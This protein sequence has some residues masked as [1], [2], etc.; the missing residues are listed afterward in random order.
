MRLH[1]KL[2]ADL[3]V[4]RRYLEHFE[5]AGETPAS[6]DTS[7]RQESNEDQILREF[8]SSHEIGRVNFKRL[9]KCS[10]ATPLTC[11]INGK[12]V[13]SGEHNWSQLLVAITEQ[14]LANG[15]QSLGLLKNT[16]L[17]GI[18]PFFVTKNADYDTC[19]KLSN[20]KWI[21]TNYD[22][23]KLVRIIGNLC[24][25]C[26][27]NLS[28]V[29]ITYK[30]NGDTTANKSQ[31]GLGAGYPPPPI[32]S[33]STLDA[34]VIELITDVLIAHFPNGFRLNSPIE[35]RR[36]RSFVPK[37]LD[38]I[39]TMSDQEL[40]TYITSSG[41]FCNGK[42][43]PVLADVKIRIKELAE[44]Y[45]AGGAQVIFYDEFYGKNENWLF[46]A[47]VISKDV[48][49]V[50]LRDLF[51]R[52]SFAQTY[53]GFAKS[54]VSVTLENEI[55]RV[56]NGE[57]LLSS[58]QLAERLTYIPI[59]KI[60]LV[61]KNNED[62]I[63]NGSNAY[64]HISQIEITDDEL[65]AIRAAT[66]RE[67]DTAGYILITDLPL[68][69]IEERNSELSL[70]AVRNAVYR[71]CL[72]EEF[73]NKRGVI[74]TRKGDVTDLLT[75]IKAHF[76]TIDKCTLA[77]LMN[78]VQ[79]LTGKEHRVKTM[80]AA[81]NVMVRI[82]GDTYLA[83]KYVHFDIDKIDEAIEMVVKNDHLPIKAFTAFS[84][85]PPCGQKWSI[86]LLESYCRRFSRMFRFDTP[87]VKSL[88][89]G[90]VIRKSCVMDYE[91]IMIEA[92]ANAKI[93][94]TDPNVWQFLYDNGYAERRTSSTVKKIMDKA[95]A[96]REKRH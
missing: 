10:E 84:A 49:I 11:S 46:R 15:N 4:Y 81:N 29:N 95:K 18:E 57:V 1:T 31:P 16:P 48:L 86:F 74:I 75:I 27:V 33:E 51:P 66:I 6:V 76:R 68:S 12:V 70:K 60:K 85:Y 17:Y 13:I 34:L 20:G 96:I 62:F 40:T 77:E 53:F 92:V 72:S 37:D 24:R 7:T 65:K 78:F 56:W 35:M 83:D 38:K 64:S 43:Y 23:P 71:I 69:D 89:A 28:D 63:W 73:D 45:F 82:D 79:E 19:A 55:L 26:G 14:F 30:L 91:Q 8:Q 9:L 22:P 94:L 42:I 39:L 52:L 67:C 93:H 54:P 5:N 59:D 21:K 50:I 44:G 41:T 61:L 58:D 80:E 25:H 2:S 87:S 32:E 90:A 88:N 3:T 36:F 47:S